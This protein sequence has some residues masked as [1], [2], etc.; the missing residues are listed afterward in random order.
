MKNKIRSVRADT[1]G[2]QARFLAGVQT[3]IAR[4]DSRVHGLR[5]ARGIALARQLC[6]KK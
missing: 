6:A 4:Y 5:T 3:C 1:L 2:N